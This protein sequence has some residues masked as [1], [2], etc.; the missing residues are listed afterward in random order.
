M[1]KKFTISLLHT[2]I[3]RLIIFAL[4]GV[5][6]ACER[7]GV[8]HT[9]GTRT[10]TLQVW[11]HA[12]Q[13]T[14]RDVIK[15]QVNR[16]N[17]ANS[18][19]NIKLTFIPERTYNS[20][21]QAAAISGELPDILEFD[22]P[23][24]YN[25]IWQ[26]QLQPLD[27]LLSAELQSDLIPSI[28]DQGSYQGSL[29]AVAQFDS[30]L[31]LYARRSLLNSVGVRIPTDAANAWTLSE[32]DELLGK[33]AEND[34][35]GAVLDLK[36]NYSGEWFTYGFSPV[37]QSAGA[38]L[39]D[40]NTYLSANHSLNG[41]EAVNAMQVI[42]SW[43]QNGY[44]DSN[45]DDAAFVS[46]RVAL[47]WVGHWEYPRYIKAFGDDLMIVPLPNFSHG[48]K[49]GQGSWVWGVNKSSKQ[50]KQAAR[51]LE[52]LLAKEEVLKMS[53]ANGAV[54]AT[55]SAINASP[56]YQSGAPLH[57]FANQLTSGYSV[58]RPKTPGYPVITNAFQQAFLDIRNSS[59]VQQA[60][61]RAVK[62]IDQDIQDNRGYGF[63]ESSEK[64]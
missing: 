60:L 50:V 25:Y 4:I 22:G 54:P 42:Q 35:D 47:S 52:F 6:L 3:N 41:G 49:T 15:D 20:Q 9:I 51:F 62:A 17:I 58:P 30:G 5:L 34:T 56:L 53:S 23:Y 10:E 13:A 12:G 16:F 44:V 27:K 14:E 39:I 2:L 18:D 8:P 33:L 29:Y 45:V 31:G 28:K 64:K 1:Q 19:I 48:S 7:T 55:Y 63:Q 43:L 37:L 40:R 38:D 24:L 32:F 57:L 59:D 36:L 46:G 61:D 11:V 21:I 26:G